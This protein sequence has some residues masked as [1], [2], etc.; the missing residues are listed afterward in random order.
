MKEV[1]MFEA[2]IISGTG[3][4]ILRVSNSKKQLNEF[5]RD[6]IHRYVKDLY[7]WGAAY[8]LNGENCYTILKKNNDFVAAFKIR[9][10]T[11]IVASPEEL[12]EEKRETEKT[13]KNDTYAE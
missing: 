7:G 1:K 12:E 2:V 5:V 13:A 4:E 11:C 8:I 10:I 6:Y 9:S 3:V